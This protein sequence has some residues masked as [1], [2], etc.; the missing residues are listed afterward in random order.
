MIGILG[1]AANK[2]SKNAGGIS[3]AIRTTLAF[4]PGYLS[5]ALPPQISMGLEVASTVG[6]IL[7]INIPS[8]TEIEAYINKR[9]S[10]ILGE[11]DRFTGTIEGIGQ[12]ASGVV[13]SIAQEADRLEKQLRADRDNLTDAEWKARQAK[14]DNLRVS[15]DLSNLQKLSRI[16]WL[17]G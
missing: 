12:V 7:G 13:L 11:I 8:V 15:A 10:P 1:K 6:S 14:I 4:N 16:D 5:M 2:I 3:K 9:I 17:L